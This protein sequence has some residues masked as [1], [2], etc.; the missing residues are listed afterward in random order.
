MLSKE[1][2]LNATDLKTETVKVPEWGGEVAIRAMTGTERD[3]FE[4]SVASDGKID[5]VNI[6]AK[7]CALTIVDQAGVRLFTDTDVIALGAKSAKALDRIFAR[8][9]KLS[10]ISKDDI[11]EME[12]NSEAIQSEDSLLN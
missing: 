8:S 3:A 7:L 2:I 10:G 1:Q 6:R 9:Q 5:M 12:K 11:K 4:M